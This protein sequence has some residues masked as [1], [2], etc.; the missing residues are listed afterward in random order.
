M[1]TGYP[2]TDP[3]WHGLYQV[4]VTIFQEDTTD[5]TSD[6]IVMIKVPFMILYKPR[7]PI[8]YYI[9]VLGFLAIIAAAAYYFLVFAKAAIKETVQR[10]RRDDIGYSTAV[11]TDRTTGLELN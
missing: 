10:G 8:F 2:R 3:P 7:R 11:D 5:V 6:A 1:T 9:C 4:K